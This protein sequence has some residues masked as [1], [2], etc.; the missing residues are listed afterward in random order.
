MNVF[1]F[2]PSESR[3]MNV[4]FESR[5]GA[6]VY[7][8]LAPFFAMSASTSITRPS[9]VSDRLM[10]VASLNCCPSTCDCAT[11]SDPARSTRFIRLFLPAVRIVSPLVVVI[12][13][14][15]RSSSMMIAWLRLLRSFIFVAAV[16][17]TPFPSSISRTTSSRHPTSTTR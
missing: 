2:P 7:C 3:R 11:R 4:S 5:N 14:S 8:A 10:C 9:V 12:V 16:C 17:R 6:T 1:E 13:R 15:S